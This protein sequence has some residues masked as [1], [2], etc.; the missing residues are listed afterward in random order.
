MIKEKYDVIVVGS[1]PA[2]STTAKYCAEKG[3]DILVLER[4]AEI[5]TPK[6]CGEGLSANSVERLKLKMPKQCIAQNIDG[7]V[8]YAPN[9]KRIDIKFEGTKGFVLERKYFDKWLAFEAAR[10]GAKIIAKS[11]VYD[12]IK[13]NNFVCGVEAC[14]MGQKREIYAD[15]VVAADGAESLLAR[16]AGMKSGKKP[17]LVDTGFQY[18]MAGIDIKHPSMIVLYF[19]AKIAPRGYVWIFPK[20][21]DIANVGIGI[22]GMGAEKTAKAYLD[23]FIEKTPELRKGSIIEVNAGCIP[24][25]GFLDN[26]VSDGV[27]GVG[28]SVNQVNP[29]HGGGIAESMTAAAIAA[30]VIKAAKEKK[31]FSEKSLSAYN[32]IWWERR[33]KHLKNVEKVREAFEK[34]SDQQMNDLAE[35]LSGEDLN[36]MAHGKNLGKIA[37]ILVKYRMKGFARMLGL[38]K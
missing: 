14:V 11:C 4:N 3:L 23:S 25:G 17:S 35:V 5:G 2:G 24:V 16:K 36:D 27:I 15:V 19:G 12:V 22:T 31:D 38:K 34:M 29:I 13:K 8:V 18:E 7:A 26:M 1:G 6:R 37:K 33:G 30:D 9:G 32:K 21:K 28:D 20:G 10:S